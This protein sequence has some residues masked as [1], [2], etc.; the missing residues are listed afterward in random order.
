MEKTRKKRGDERGS[1]L[2]EAAAA[3][4]IMLLIFVALLQ[5]Y[6]WCVTG[7]FCQ[8]ASFYASKGMTLGYRLNLVRRGAR[9]AAIA[10]SG[11]SA[12]ST[13]GRET[14]DARNYMSYGDASGVW[15]RYWYPQRNG[16]PELYL[17][18]RYGEDS[19]TTAVTMLNQP[20]IRPELGRVLGIT[21]NPEP[22][23]STQGFN[24]SALYLEE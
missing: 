9:V 8:Y 14:D 1:T 12:G 21:S 10:I 15:Y 7:I 4:V 17:H 13:S 3:L 11:D 18:G 24:Y 19:I 5:I 20:L 22:T 23:A 2:F 16:E 6:Q